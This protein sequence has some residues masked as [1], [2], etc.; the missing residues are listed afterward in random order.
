MSGLQ[1][2]DQTVKK[3]FVV[4]ALKLEVCLEYLE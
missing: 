2:L 1:Y 3:P 4:V